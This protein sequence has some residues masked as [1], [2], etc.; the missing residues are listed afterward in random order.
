MIRIKK[1]YINPEL[2]NIAFIWLETRIKVINDS[3]RYLVNTICLQKQFIYN[4]STEEVILL[5]YSSADS[6]GNKDNFKF[7]SF[8]YEILSNTDPNCSEFFINCV[9]KSQDTEYPV[10]EQNTEYS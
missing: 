3:S 2:Y 5:G 6:F 9:N 4:N 8:K 7:K 1:C 10:S